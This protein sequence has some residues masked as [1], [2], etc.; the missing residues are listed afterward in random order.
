MI[1]ENVGV[2]SVESICNLVASTNGGCKR[3]GVNKS[4]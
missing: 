2:R 1:R 3:K 4:A